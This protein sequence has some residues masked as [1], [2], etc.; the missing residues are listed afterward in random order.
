MLNSGVFCTPL[1][2]V[3]LER[4]KEAWKDRCYSHPLSWE[5]SGGARDG[6]KMLYKFDFLLG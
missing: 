5:F 2:C 1:F 4:A 6:S 3:F